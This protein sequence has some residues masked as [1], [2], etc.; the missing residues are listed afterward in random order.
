MAPEWP[1]KSMHIEEAPKSDGPGGMP[2]EIWGKVAT[3]LSL[4]DCCRLASTCQQLWKLD[5]PHVV[6][7]ERCPAQGAVP[8]SS[9]HWPRL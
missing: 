9:S 1:V 5:L 6:L 7:G 8:L 3:I 2:V 4:Q